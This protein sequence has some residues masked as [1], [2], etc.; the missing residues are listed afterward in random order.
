L[1]E[2]DKYTKTNAVLVLEL[3]RPLLLP[4]L[5]LPLLRLRPELL[6][7]LLLLRPPLLYANDT[8]LELVFAVVELLIDTDTY[9]S[10][11]V[12]EYEGQIPRAGII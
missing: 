11:F 8:I 9:F 2:Y 10:I 12:V 5:L 7:L 6:L 4:V 3:L 1:D